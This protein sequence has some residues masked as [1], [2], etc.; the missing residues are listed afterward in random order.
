[1][2]RPLMLLRNPTSSGLRTVIL[3]R[4]HL[5]YRSA[6]AAIASSCSRMVSSQMAACWTGTSA[7]LGPT[8]SQSSSGQV[9]RA[10]AANTLRS[11]C[12]TS[13]SPSAWAPCEIGSRASSG[14][15]TSPGTGASSVP[16]RSP[17]AGAS[18]LAGTAKASSR[19]SRSARRVADTAFAS[20]FG[21]CVRPCRASAPTRNMPRSWSSSRLPSLPRP[22]YSR[23]FCLIRRVRPRAS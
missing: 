3:P 20:R 12:R 21:Y 9:S 1:M 4:R 8:R 10:P 22:P 6:M 15:P 17:V 11:P 14:R 2:A 5:L 13:T 19:W 18:S 23:R 7:M 16:R